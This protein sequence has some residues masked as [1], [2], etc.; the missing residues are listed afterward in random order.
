LLRW[1][2][3]AV[4]SGGLFARAA[5]RGLAELEQA[6]THPPAQVRAPAPATL[7]NR[8]P[9]AFRS[10]YSADEEAYIDNAGLIILWP[11]Y[12]PLF[13]HL[14]LVVDKRFKDPAAVHRGVGLLQHLATQEL[15]PPEYQLLLPK[16]LCG[17]DPSAV[18]DFGP[19][20]TD[21]EAQECT[22]LLG[23]AIASAPILRDM[24]IP[25]FRGTFLL[26]KGV[27]SVRDDTWLL[28]VERASYDVVLDRFPWSMSWIKLPW[29]SAPLCVEW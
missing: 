25:G 15:E 29:M 1:L 19:P 13:A 12:S 27:L 28:R 10:A 5:A 4:A 11:F 23:A 18:F 24:S 17:M 7:P 26:R 21:A 2:R 14:E 9:A 8:R 6:A 3:L 20:V 22:D 16:L